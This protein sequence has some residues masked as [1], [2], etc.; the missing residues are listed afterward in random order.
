MNDF[1]AAA[2]VAAD[3]ITT[4]RAEAAEHRLAAGSARRAAVP[5]ETRRSWFGGRPRLNAAVA[6]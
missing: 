5:N 1:Q 2:A 6:K 4:L 3:R